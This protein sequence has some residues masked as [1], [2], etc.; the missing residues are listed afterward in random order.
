LLPLG[1]DQAAWEALEAALEADEFDEV[2]EDIRKARDLALSR[3]RI[4]PNQGEA[5]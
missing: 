4:G 3:Q 2:A 1:R 5:K